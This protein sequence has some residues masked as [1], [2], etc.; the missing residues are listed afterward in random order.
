MAKMIPEA[1]HR[2]EFSDC[3]CDDLGRSL[4]VTQIGADRESRAAGIA[5]FPGYGLGTG[6]IAINDADLRTFTR[7]QE[8]SGAAHA[9]CRSRH[10]AGFVFHSH[11]LEPFLVRS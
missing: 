5:D 6:G 2:A 9:G 11:L 8:R 4:A 7:E 10:Q 3:A 1:V